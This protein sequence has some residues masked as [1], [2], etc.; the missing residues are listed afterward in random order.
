MK[1]Q[2]FF[3]MAIIFAIQGFT[4]TTVTIG[5]GTT[6]VNTLP[7]GSYYNYSYTQQI[8]TAAEIGA[9]TGVITS[10]GFEYIYASSMTVNNVKVFIGN[11]SN[12]TFATTS[13]WIPTSSMQEVYNGSITFQN[14]W[15][16]I[17]LDN[18][19]Q[20]DNISNLV[21]CVINGNGDYEGSQ[22]RFNVHTNPGGQGSL[23]TQNDYNPYSSTTSPTSGTISAN[24]N[25]IKFIFDTP[26]TC[27]A[28]TALQASNPTSSPT[29]FN[30]SWTD[31]SG[32]LWNIQY[33]PAAQ[34]DW[35]NATTI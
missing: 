2:L 4:Q 24:R 26:P 34:I 22:N 29:S 8:Y 11:T 27:P 5:S 10:I 19:Y 14:G 20:W 1:K 13:S 7:I 18:Y 15:V 3:L 21:V 30:L 31:A 17:T 33:M 35:A 6:G 23:Y 28:P 25:N 32:T 16:F 12:T 9:Q